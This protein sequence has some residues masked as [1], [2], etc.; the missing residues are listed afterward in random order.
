VSKQGSSLAFCSKSRPARGFC[1]PHIVAATAEWAHF[2]AFVNGTSTTLL[3][4]FGKPTLADDASGVSGLARS[5]IPM[6]TPRSNQGGLGHA[7]VIYLCPSVWG[8]REYTSASRRFEESWPSPIPLWPVLSSCLLVLLTTHDIPMGDPRGLRF[9][10]RFLQDTH[11]HS[12]SHWVAD[13]PR[14]I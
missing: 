14:P 7:L 4:H 2:A 8:R 13:W 5:P 9:P 1:H 12:P 11:A 3:R 6:A 10:S